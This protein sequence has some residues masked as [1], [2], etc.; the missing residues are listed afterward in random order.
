MLVLASKDA[1][2]RT[3]LC[4][5][6]GT[7]EAAHITMTQ[8]VWLGTDAL[9]PERLAERLSEVTQRTGD[10]VPLSGAAQGGNEIA[11]AMENASQR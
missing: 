1:P 11:K 3:I 2:N 5:G 7:F 4:A 6:A 8:G 9:T 10:T